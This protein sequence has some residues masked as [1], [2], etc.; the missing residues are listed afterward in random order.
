MVEFLAREDHY[1]DVVIFEAINNAATIGLGHH[2]NAPVIGFTSMFAT[3]FNMDMVGTPAPV[4][5]VPHELMLFS[6]RM[7]FVQRLENTLI[8]AYER[9]KFNDILKRQDETYQKVFTTK[10]KPTIFELHRSVSLVLVNQHFS[11]DHPQPYATNMIDIGGIHINTD[12]PKQL[13]KKILQFV[14]KSANGVIYFSMG[15]IVKS[16]NLPIAMRDGLLSAFGKLKERV[17]WKWED[18]DLPGKPANVMIRNWFPQEDI[19]AHP[20]VKLFISH[21]GLLS[22]METVYHAVPII[23][24]P[25]FGDH[26]VN[27]FRAQSA[28]YGLTVAFANI[29]EESI[30]WSIDEIL[31]NDRFDFTD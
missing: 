27:M 31:N 1:Y 23:G 6:D 3:L 2:F 26:F 22:V 10:N 17:L 15:S 7:S 24:I 8:T 19:L 9:Y 14:E 25:I 4:S 13:P 11:F 30:T 18:P 5:F 21:G 12:F 29:T 28:G 16:S 20:N